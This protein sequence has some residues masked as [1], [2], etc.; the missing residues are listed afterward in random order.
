MTSLGMLAMLFLM[1]PETV[2]LLGHKGTL[3]AHGQLVHEVSQAPLCGGA[4]QQVP[5]RPTLQPVWVSLYDD[6]AFWCVSHSSQFCVISKLAES[7]LCPF[8]YVIDEYVELAT[9]HVRWEL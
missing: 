8:I 3:L 2:G 1:P 6:T 7:R 4:F 9:V 5:L